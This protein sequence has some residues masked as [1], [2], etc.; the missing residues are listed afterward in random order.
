VGEPSRLPPLVVG[1]R[2]WSLPVTDGSAAALIETLCAVDPSGDVP[3][4]VGALAG[5]PSLLL[6]TVCMA[7]VDDRLRP[8]SLDEAAQ[9]LAR[10]ARELLSS[11]D[12]CPPEASAEPTK[13]DWDGFANG[14]GQARQV[15]E[16]AVA[17]VARRESSEVE[18]ARLLGLLHEAPAWLA[19]V[20][21]TSAD[22]ATAALPGWLVEAMQSESAAAVAVRQAR[23]FLREGQVPGELADADCQASCR[24]AGSA[25][26]AWLFS[27]G[28]LGNC[29][30]TL[31]AKMAR[32]S[33]LEG[34]FDRAVETEKLES[35]AEFA[36]GA[37]HEINN[38][39]A[40]IVGRAQL[41]LRDEHDAER[42]RSLALIASQAMRVNEMIA[43]MRLFAR[44]PQ[45]R[46]ELFDVVELVDRVI[47]ELLPTAGPLGIVLKRAGQPGPIELEADFTQMAVVLRAIA[48]NAIEAMG[49]GGCVEIAV[50][51]DSET[52]ALRITD[53]GPG[54]TDEERRHIFDPFY[55]ARQAG[56]GLGLGLS[57]CWRIVTNHGG[58]LDI[59]SRQ[60]HGSVFIATLPRHR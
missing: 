55:S 9:W 35:L 43:D 58:R 22:E 20:G 26:K 12:S 52:V 41:F 42:R 56:R 48:S 34:Q 27:L 60:G 24:Q 38:P 51:A 21:G 13:I 36:A 49:Q 33:L 29:L 8:R 18:F 44:P 54:M 23:A 30:A 45:P 59:E 10:H 2:R 1:P 7:G 3:R 11:G 5:D 40:V 19:L 15:A 28:S 32:L 47:E 57:K 4:L 53:D 37:G 25:A 46:P 31:A 50:C 16:L 6:W 39:L 14:V 17:I